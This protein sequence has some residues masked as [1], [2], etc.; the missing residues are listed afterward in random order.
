[1]TLPLSLVM[2]TSRVKGSKVLEKTEEMDRRSGRDVTGPEA[3][4]GTTNG[5]ARLQKAV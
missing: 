5:V 1:M 4:S 2:E 3:E